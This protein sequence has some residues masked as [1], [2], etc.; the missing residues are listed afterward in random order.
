M[1]LL[2]C[3]ILSLGGNVNTRRMLQPDMGSI[4]HIKNQWNHGHR[5]LPCELSKL[6][7]LMLLTSSDTKK[8]WCIYSCLQIPPTENRFQYVRRVYATA[9]NFPCIKALYKTVYT[10]KTWNFKWN[11][12]AISDLERHSW[13]LYCEIYSLFSRFNRI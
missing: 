7:N 9:I 8:H 6:S 1:H 2:Y 13:N 10:S 4:F 11:S 5:K 12:R 3:R